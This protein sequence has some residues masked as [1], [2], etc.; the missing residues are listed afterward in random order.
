MPV[1]KTIEKYEKLIPK[2]VIYDKLIPHLNYS[3]LLDS[4]TGKIND[5]WFLDNMPEL[6][7]MLN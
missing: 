4:E 3:Y 5:L 7:T 6:K 2:L 1:S